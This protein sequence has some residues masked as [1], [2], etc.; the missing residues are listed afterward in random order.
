[1]VNLNTNEQSFMVQQR[2]DPVLGTT[3]VYYTEHTAEVQH[4]DSTNAYQSLDVHNINGVQNAAGRYALPIDIQVVQNTFVHEYRSK[5][6]TDIVNLNIKIFNVTQ[7][8]ENLNDYR[9]LSGT[10]IVAGWYISKRPYWS[11]NKQSTIDTGAGQLITSGNASLPFD[12]GF[13]LNS[14]DYYRFVIS[15]DNDFELQGVAGAPSPLGGTQ[16]IPYIERSYTGETEVNVKTEGA[17]IHTT[18]LDFYR[19]GTNTSIILSDGESYN[20]NT[21]KAIEDSGTI[22]I[23]S[24]DT[25][26]SITHYKQINHDLVTIAGTSA[27]T[28]VTA[29]VNALN[30][31]FAVQ[32]LGLGGDYI[33]TLPTLDGVDVTSNFA[34]GQDPIGDSIY[35][36]ATAT[37]QHDARVWSDET[38]NEPGEF[39]EVKI[40]GRGQFMLGLYSV[41]DGDLTEIQNNTGNGHTGYKWANAFYNYGSYIAP[42]TTYG[43]NSSLSY[44]PG[45]QTTA[46]MMRYNTIVQDNL[47]N[48]NPANPAL[49][50]V[51]INAQGY[52]AVYYF[53]EGRTNEY[54]MTARS[55]YTL[56]SGEYGLMV[57][58][59]NG[60]VQLTETPKR[61][62]VDPA[63]PILTYHFIESPDG[64]FQYPLF[65]TEEEANY[66]DSVNDGTG[67]SHTHTF[68]D[69]LTNATWYMP[70][71]G[72]TMTATSAP[73]D[74]IDATYNEISSLTDADLVPTTFAANN[75][76]Q[77][78]A[79]SVNIQVT[80]AGATWSSS[81]NITPAG[82]GL[83]YDG[84]SLVQ[85]T[86]VD[87]G[88]DT[89]YT[90]TVTRANSYG[91]SVG[92]MTITATDVPVV[93]SLL[94]PW[95]KAVVINGANEYLMQVSNSNSFNIL[96]MGGMNND[97]WGATNGKTSTDTDARPWSISQVV[98]IDNSKP[99]CYFSQAEN[100]AN[101]RISLST[102]E[103]GAGSKIEFYWGRSTGTNGANSN[104]CQFLFDKPSDG[105]YGYYIDTTGFRPNQA[106][107]TVSALGDN[108]RFKQVDLSTGTVTD[109]TGT[110]TVVG[111][112]R[113]NRSL[114]G[115][116]YVGRESGSQSFNSNQSLKVAST[117]ISTIKR[118]FLLPD[119][120]EISMQVRDPQQWVIDYRDGT[121]QRIAMNANTYDYDTYPERCVSLWLMGDGA[122]DSYSNNVRNDVKTADQN[123]TMLRLQNMVS[124]DIETVN[125]TG[126]S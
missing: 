16:N 86:L 76:T 35:A 124:N 107:S 32:P 108:F 1:M 90:V 6:N 95:S 59:V 28:S 51:G 102:H 62:A 70:D 39:Y 116:F 93:S 73:T 5:L 79:T 46:Q 110:W 43:S 112:G 53:D 48:A 80:P 97:V 118:D 13:S 121:Q 100:Y 15:G 49:F 85:G 26:V 103:T 33:S 74:T 104:G 122:S 64:V 111:D 91:S 105:W 117:L 2:V 14:G 12:E 40:T 55:S 36:V 71:N 87:V 56:P 57:K 123:Y 50:K 47:E 61:T 65:S 60:A 98:Y 29:V 77:E 17:K 78:E 84:S 9:V 23:V 69:D 4:E 67:T 68:V 25:D 75:I 52:I 42:W 96:N 38:I 21:I 126:L 44:G 41:A 115:D 82:S 10:G 63:A 113:L 119:D 94:T 101:D 45:W 114:N 106:Q 8:P 109:I 31:L 54:V 18:A 81:V 66:F 125:I 72:G 30:G 99:Q 58:L 37:G 7:S 34:E 89:V 27:G 19:D 88:A 24:V 92:T 11:L 83:V 120:T 3:S 20:V 22:K